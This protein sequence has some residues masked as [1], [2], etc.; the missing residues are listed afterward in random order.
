MP[1]TA[2]GRLKPRRATQHRPK[3]R[4]NGTLRNWATRVV[5]HRRCT[6]GA[7][8]MH[9]YPRKPWPTTTGD[10]AWLPVHRSRRRR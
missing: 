5:R 7:A 3:A 10:R 6:S 2:R 9:C 1:K 8:R 4:R